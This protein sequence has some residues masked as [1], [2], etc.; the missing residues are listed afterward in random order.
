MTMMMTMVLVKA[1][2]V[3]FVVLLALVDD[4]TSG[5]LKIMPPSHK[6][7]SPTCKHEK[8]LLHV[9]VKFGQ[10]KICILCNGETKAVGA[11]SS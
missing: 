10:E 9:R 3:Y 11:R 5:S 6:R 8:L 7:C 1:V 2:M 4:R